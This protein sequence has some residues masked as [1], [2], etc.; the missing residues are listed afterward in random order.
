VGE[1]RLQRPCQ[2][3]TTESSTSITPADMNGDGLTDL[4]VPHRDG[5]QGHVYLQ[6][7]GTDSLAFTR[8]PFGDANATIRMTVAA[9]LDRDGRLDIVAI[10]EERG[11]RVYFARADGSYGEALP[12]GA[13]G[14]RPY[15]LAVA[16][17]DADGATDVIVG[18]VRA[19][20]VVLYNTGNGR[21][22]ERV[23]FGDAEGSAYGFA[24][25]DLDADGALDIA[26]ARSDARNVVY[27]GTPARH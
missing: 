22:F 24:I 15:A 19:Q 17:M 25:A 10:D 12:I 6:Q 20:P 8:V 7:R 16:D 9:D 23:P 14:G 4:V 5:G 11:A 1:G 3:F 18:Y 27:F 21:T 13:A 2:R 26:I